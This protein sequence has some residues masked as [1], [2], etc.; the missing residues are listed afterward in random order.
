[1]NIAHS[2][3]CYSHPYL[4][5]IKDALAHNVLID[6][7]GKACYTPSSYARRRVLASRMSAKEAR[8]KFTDVL[9]RAYYQNEPTIVE[10]QGKVVA[11]VISPEQYDQYRQQQKQEIFRTIR[12]IDERTRDVDPDVIEA[13]IAA[14]VAE[15]RHEQHAA[16]SSRRD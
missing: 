14:A 11:V 9:S 4:F 10:R 12:E 6:I 1:M 3:H 15:V 16:T 8:D 5:P 2:R 13:E 7:V